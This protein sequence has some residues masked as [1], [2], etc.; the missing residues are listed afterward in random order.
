MTETEQLL[1]DLH[2]A[3]LRTHESSRER[4]LALTK[5]EE[6]ELWLIRAKEREAP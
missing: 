6:C 2:N 3:I 5:L 1:I 4:A